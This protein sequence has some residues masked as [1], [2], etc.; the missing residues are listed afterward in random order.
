[1]NYFCFTLKYVNFI[2][3]YVL[4]ILSESSGALT[5][6]IFIRWM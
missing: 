4:L 2:F 1:M 6:F 3:H 5:D